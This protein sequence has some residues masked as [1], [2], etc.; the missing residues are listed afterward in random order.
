MK[1]TAEYEELMVK[2]SLR[3]ETP[4]V[5]KKLLLL[6]LNGTLLCRPK[7]QNLQSFRRRPYVGALLEYLAQAW[8]AS[9]G[10]LLFRSTHC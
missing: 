1:P 9:G 2:P 6:D 10:C 8:E 4:T 5:T 3:L 7:T